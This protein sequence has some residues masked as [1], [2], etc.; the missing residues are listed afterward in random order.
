M[1]TNEE[2]IRMKIAKSTC[3]PT[4][5]IGTVLYVLG[6]IDEDSYVGFGENR[7]SEGIVDKLLER[8]IRVDKPQIGAIILIS[9]GYR[10]EHMGLVVDENPFKIYHRPGL[11]RPGSPTRIVEC[12]SLDSVVTT[13]LQYP[14]REYYIRT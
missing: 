1:F 11:H 12:D 4:N 8:M 9:S 2:K 10:I 5:C 3:E 7:Y 6:V 13:Y 14:I